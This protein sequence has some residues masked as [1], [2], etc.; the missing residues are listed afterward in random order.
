MTSAIQDIITKFK[1]SNI[2]YNL[3][4][5]GLSAN[6]NFNNFYFEGFTLQGNIVNTYF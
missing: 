4:T 6:I 3:L 1:L 2:F 5:S